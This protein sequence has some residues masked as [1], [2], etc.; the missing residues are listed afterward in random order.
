MVFLSSQSPG[1]LKFYDNSIFVI[2]VRS[3]ESV[4]SGR[5][6]KSVT[7]VKSVIQRVNVLFNLFLCAV[8]IITITRNVQVIRW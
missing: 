1:T 5:S 8:L 7:S 3:V 4:K 6:V 2:N